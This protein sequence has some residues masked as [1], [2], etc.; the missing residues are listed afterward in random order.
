MGSVLVKPEAVSRSIIGTLRTAMGDRRGHARL[1][2]NIGKE[3]R[4]VSDCC[5]DLSRHHR[6]SC[7]AQQLRILALADSDLHVG[8]GLTTRKNALR[9]AL[10]PQPSTQNSAKD[11][12]EITL[13]PLC[14]HSREPNEA[15]ERIQHCCDGPCL[16]L[17][18]AN[19]K[20]AVT[21]EDG[22]AA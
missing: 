1:K 14:A 19:E 12:R 21:G 17:F 20:R 3:T 18:A 15:C 10:R 16:D 22:D 4:P 8:L 7:D 9:L 6:R 11:V 13:A 2:R 5:D